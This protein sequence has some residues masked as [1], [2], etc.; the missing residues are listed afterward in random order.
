VIGGAGKG[1]EY[2]DN[3][4]YTSSF[5]SHTFSGKAIGDEVTG[6]KIWVITFETDPL[7]NVS[8]VTV[9]GNTATNIHSYSVSTKFWIADDPG[10]TTADIDV[11]GSGTLTDCTIFV[12]R[13][14]G[15]SSD[16]PSDTGDPGAFTD[17]NTTTLNVPSSGFVLAFARESSA[18]VGTFAWSG[19][20]LAD[21]DEA[22][23]GDPG[24]L[25][26]GM[27]I[28]CKAGAGAATP[29]SITTTESGGRNHGTVVVAWS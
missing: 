14:W 21:A 20:T 28:A 5:S 3:E 18:G 11:T 12:G 8:G 1:I 26:I 10:G 16:T 9:G 24:T 22:F 7:D 6:R 23:D 17:P 27:A 29:A 4:Q 25:T 19:G 15:H 2:T 13:I